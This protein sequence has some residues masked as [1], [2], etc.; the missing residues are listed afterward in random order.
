MT[1]TTTTNLKDGDDDVADMDED[2]WLLI[3][4]PRGGTPAKDAH[5]ATTERVTSGPTHGSP[6]A[7]GE[8]ECGAT[9]STHRLD[10]RGGQNHGRRPMGNQP[11]YKMMC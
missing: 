8:D 11:R 9:I 6:P 1:T 10:N 5:A 7:C 4:G 2:A 3:D